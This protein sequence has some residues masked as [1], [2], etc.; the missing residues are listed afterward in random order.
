MSPRWAGIFIGDHPLGLPNRAARRVFGLLP[1]PRRCKFCNAPFRGPYAGAVKRTGY[2]RYTESAAGGLEV[3]IGVASG[4]ANRSRAGADGK[5]RHER[6]LFE[7]QLVR[8]KLGDLMGAM[9]RR[10]STGSPPALRSRS[11][12]TRIASVF[13]KVVCGA[14]FGSARDTP[15]H[16][17]LLAVESRSGE[18]RRRCGFRSLTRLLR[19]ARRNAVPSAPGPRS[20]SRRWSRR[21]R[22]AAMLARR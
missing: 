15:H 4:E 19:V 16:Y 7:A 22:Q 12:A 2:A 21:A 10:K 5:R 3:G 11:A 9:V 6:A 18:I 17:G 8:W 1:S 13:R 14:A 20:R